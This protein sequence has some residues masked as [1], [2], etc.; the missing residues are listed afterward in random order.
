MPSPRTSS[1]WIEG[2]RSSGCS[3]T[4]FQ[5]RCFC[6]KN[7]LCGINV[8]GSIIRC[9]LLN[10]RIQLEQN[11]VRVRTVVIKAQEVAQEAQNGTRHHFPKRTTNTAKGLVLPWLMFPLSNWQTTHIFPACT[12]LLC[13]K[14]VAAVIHLF[15]RLFCYFLFA[16]KVEHSFDQKNNAECENIV[17]IAVTTVI[18]FCKE[19]VH[20]VDGWLYVLVPLFLHDY[21]QLLSSLVSLK[22]LCFSCACNI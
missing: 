1:L 19:F 4:G 20:T 12:P 9:R 3:V 2:M 13:L 22:C 6:L 11:F 5:C 14:S 10:Y 18:F 17:N 21:E 8:P 7:R 15:I 16:A